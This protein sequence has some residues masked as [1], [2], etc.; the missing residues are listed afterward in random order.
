MRRTPNGNACA[1]RLGVRVRCG[2]ACGRS[3]SCSCAVR[4]SLTARARCGL[5]RASPRAQVQLKRR[6]QRHL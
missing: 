1:G 4:C 5:M 6:E 3:L 2:V